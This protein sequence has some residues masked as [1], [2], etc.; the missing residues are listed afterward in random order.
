MPDEYL[1]KWLYSGEEVS[2]GYLRAREGIVEEVCKGQPPVDVTP[3][4]VIP[5]FVNSHIHIGD[6]FAHPAPSGTVEEVVGPGGYKHRMLAN[7]SASEKIA[8]M[9]TSLDTMLRTGTCAFIDFREE[10]I[11]GVRDLRGAMGESPL[12]AKILG[13][14]SSVDGSGAD[15]DALLRAVDGLAFSSHS[16]WPAEVLEEASAK[17]RSA[18]KMFSLHASESRREDIDAILDLKPSFVV[19]MTRATGDDVAAC[20][21]AGVP[22]VVCPSSNRFFGL[23]PDIRGMLDAGA[24]VALGTDNAMIC[25]PDM[26][27]EMRAAFDAAAGT[28]RLAPAEAIR[29]ATLSGRKVLNPKGKITTEL[30]TSDSLVV[31]DVQE[32]EDPLLELVSSVCPACVSAVTHRG[33][34]WRRDAWTT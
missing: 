21:A 22:I 27:S 8:G 34:V 25:A 23:V 31:L 13:R 10:G 19:H 30:S 3:S 5:G 4:V 15:M 24:E 16:D 9:K 7:A 11:E 20:A 26:T 17:C 12:E 6:S 18:G 2:A 32:G 33:K 28:E 29:L 1:G 14:P